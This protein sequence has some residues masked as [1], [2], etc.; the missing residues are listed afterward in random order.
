MCVCWY[1]ILEDTRFK[2]PWFFRNIEKIGDNIVDGSSED[3]SFI[4]NMIDSGVI[5]GVMVDLS[6]R[7][8]HEKRV[9]Y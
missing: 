4:R 6:L 9:V 1:G 2:Y 7:F 5:D 3:V 8:G